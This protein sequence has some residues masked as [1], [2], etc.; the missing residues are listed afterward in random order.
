MHRNKVGAWLTP[1][2]AAGQVIM[3]PPGL[4]AVILECVNGF[5]DAR[6]TQSMSTIPLPTD[7]RRSEA[8]SQGQTCDKCMKALQDMGFNFMQISAMSVWADGVVNM[9]FTMP[10]SP[11]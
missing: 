9:L 7:Q 10:M 5:I 6:G 2:S 4:D 8:C 3:P 11:G 1:S